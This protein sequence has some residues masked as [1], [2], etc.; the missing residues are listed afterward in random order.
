MLQR[1]GKD[2]EGREGGI[3]CFVD[4]AEGCYSIL[5]KGVRCIIMSLRLVSTP[6]S[7]PAVCKNHVAY[8]VVLLP[9]LLLL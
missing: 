5:N 4:S 9:Q 7:V 6:L 2:E 8:G 3:S 1:R